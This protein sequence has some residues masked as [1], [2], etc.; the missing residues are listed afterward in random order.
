MVPDHIK[1]YPMDE[2]QESAYQRFADILRM[3]A[4]PILE[5]ATVFGHF[6]PE[7][8]M[9]IHEDCQRYGLR[10]QVELV[11][12]ADENPPVKPIDPEQWAREMAN[13]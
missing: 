2:L 7:Q 8:R 4:G 10:I 1:T 3:Y 9:Q 6:T 12:H 11:D 5:E 13:R